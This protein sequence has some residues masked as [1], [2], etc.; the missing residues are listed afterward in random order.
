MELKVIEL[1]VAAERY[2]GMVSRFS[3]QVVTP[4]ATGSHDY[5]NFDSFDRLYETPKQNAVRLERGF[6]SSQ[7]DVEESFPR[8]RYKT[9]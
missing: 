5:G 1:D 6:K 4:T 8:W 7:L 2:V 9:P 3:M